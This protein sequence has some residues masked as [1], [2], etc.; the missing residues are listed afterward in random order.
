[1]DQT[2]ITSGDAPASCACLP[3]HY[4][5]SLQTANGDALDLKPTTLDTDNATCASLT[6]ASVDGCGTTVFVVP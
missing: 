5:V 6:A 3:E 2:Y 1:V 4:T